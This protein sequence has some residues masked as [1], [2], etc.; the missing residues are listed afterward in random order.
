MF[1]GTVSQLRSR[2]EAVSPNNQ[3]DDDQDP[4]APDEARTIKAPHV[5]PIAL[6]VRVQRF[7]NDLCFRAHWD[8][9]CCVFDPS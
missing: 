4:V 6:I 8:E 7:S 3:K 1:R 2:A 9:I 5:S